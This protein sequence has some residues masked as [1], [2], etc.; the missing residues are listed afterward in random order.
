MLT[1]FAV[2]AGGAPL[3]HIHERF[4]ARGEAL[5]RVSRSHALEK[6]CFCPKLARLLSRT[7]LSLGLVEDARKAFELVEALTW[8]NVSLEKPDTSGAH[9]KSQTRASLGKSLFL[10]ELFARLG[11][12]EYNAG[13][14]RVSV[15]LSHAFA[16]PRRVRQFTGVPKHNRM[17]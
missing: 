2:L 3:N 1:A 5:A 16:L 11:C 4:L 9:I 17:R 7:R 14:P 8:G 15:P 6:L 10:C 12:A 13:V